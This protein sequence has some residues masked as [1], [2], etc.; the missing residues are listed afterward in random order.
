M[1]PTGAEPTLARALQQDQ[2][3]VRIRLEFVER[4]VDVAKH[5][6]RHGIDRF[7]PLRRMI[8]AAPSRRAIRSGSGPATAA[9]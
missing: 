2:A 5:L 3:N 8:P 6:Q 7:R 4:L 9:A 1:S